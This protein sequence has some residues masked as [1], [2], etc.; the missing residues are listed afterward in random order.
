MTRAVTLKRL[1][2]SP[3][4]PVLYVPF[5]TP[6]RRSQNNINLLFEIY[7]SYPQGKALVTDRHCGFHGCPSNVI[8]VQRAGKGGPLEG[9]FCRGDS[10]GFMGVLHPRFIMFGILSYG[11]GGPRVNNPKRTRPFLSQAEQ[12]RF[13]SVPRARVCH[14]HQALQG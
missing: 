5:V 14:G 12:S 7:R 13:P 1:S 2:T 11:P 4:S 9:K 8:C 6:C 10:G 3:P